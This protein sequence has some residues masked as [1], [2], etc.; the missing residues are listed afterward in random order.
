MYIVGTMYETGK[1]V[2]QN[3]AK[4]C[5]WYKKLA[6]NLLCEP[7]YEDPWIGSQ[8]GP[9]IRSKRLTDSGFPSLA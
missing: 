9:Q 7:E 8:S 4:A 6:E 3:I 5:Q 2:P 1:G